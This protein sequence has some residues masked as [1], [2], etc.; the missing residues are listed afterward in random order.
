MCTPSV[1]ATDG[2]R[3]YRFSIL[4]VNCLLI[5]IL[6]TI[7]YCTRWMLEM[8]HLSFQANELALVNRFVDT[9]KMC[10]K[11]WNCCSIKEK[12]M[13]TTVHCMNREIQTNHIVCG[14]ERSHFLLTLLPHKTL[15]TWLCQL[16]F[17]LLESNFSIESFSLWTDIT[18]E[19][20]VIFV[21]RAPVWAW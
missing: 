11:A 9:M 3:K 1:F 2:L 4:L 6:L 7:V 12:T 10:L 5:I 16:L 15:I 18:F 21:L 17:N 14:G 20:I 13:D 8:L 19:W